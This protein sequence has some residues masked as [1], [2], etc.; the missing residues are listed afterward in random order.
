M[1]LVR[2]WLGTAGVAAAGLTGLLIVGGP[3]RAEAA[4]GDQR[5]FS[6]DLVSAGSDISLASQDTVGR[7]VV[8]LGCNVTTNGAQVGRD[9]VVFGGNVTIVN[10]RVGRDVFTAGGNVSLR[11]HAFV[12]RDVDTAGGNL[13]VEDQSWVGRRA[14]A[15]GGTVST[16]AR[17]HV[18]SE[19]SNVA[20]PSWSGWQGSPLASGSFPPAG[21]FFWAFGTL[22]PALGFVL[23]SVLLLLIFPRQVAATGLLAQRQPVASFGLGCLGVVVAVPLK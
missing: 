7:D 3:V 17:T 8:C 14:S 19:T 12:G 18:G 15:L 5:S 20:E 9:V 10:G 22:V 6:Q 2:R 1:H 11:G 16:G 13:S 21:L 23:L 4:P